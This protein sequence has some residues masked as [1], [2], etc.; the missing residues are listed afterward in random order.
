MLN[1]Q[2]KCDILEN[3][4]PIGREIDHE[5][6]EIASSE[7]IE[8]NFLIK[9]FSFLEIKIFHYSPRTRAPGTN[10]EMIIDGR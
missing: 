3:S 9:E 6:V 10:G 8:L 2:I 5:K 1:D 4:L 7:T